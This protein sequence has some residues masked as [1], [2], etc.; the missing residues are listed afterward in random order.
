V[1]ARQHQ[2]WAEQKSDLVVWK[3]GKLGMEDL[4]SNQ[5]LWSSCP[6][7][8]GTS[9][10]SNHRLP[11]CLPAMQ[12]PSNKPSSHKAPRAEFS[13]SS[14]NVFPEDCLQVFCTVGLPSGGQRGAAVSM[15]VWSV[16]HVQEG[17]DNEIGRSSGFHSIAETLDTIVQVQPSVRGEWVLCVSATCCPKQRCC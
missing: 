10:P 17:D 11:E 4:T 5:V 8:I 12:A 15:K 1:Q 7:N 9:I 6:Y 3:G 14:P 16:I 2:W 13:L